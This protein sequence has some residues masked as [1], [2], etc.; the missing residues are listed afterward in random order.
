MKRMGRA[1]AAAV[2][3]WAPARARELVIARDK[4]HSCGG[5]GGYV[6]YEDAAEFVARV[7]KNL[8][9]V[10]IKDLH[11]RAQDVL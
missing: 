5:G 1:A 8:A 6:I 10:Y 2:I 11:S 9:R 3:L 7:E 4:S